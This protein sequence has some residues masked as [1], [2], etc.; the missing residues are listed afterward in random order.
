VPSAISWQ[1]RHLDQDQWFL[2][3]FG[4][5]EFVVLNRLD[6]W[7]VA[8]WTSGSG[9]DLGD[10]GRYEDLPPDLA[11]Q[12]WS[13][14]KDDHRVQLR[15][16]FPD[17]P[18]IARPRHPFTIGPKSN[19]F[20][21][22]GVPASVEVLGA[23]DG[24]M[25][26]L[27]TL[28]SQPLSKTWHGNRSKGSPCYSLRTRARRSVELDDWTGHDIACAVDVKNERA[29]PFPFETLF[30]DTGHLA[31]FEEGGYLWSNALRVRVDED[32][33]SGFNDVTYAP[34]PLDQASNAEEIT[35]PRD[36]RARRSK[37][38]SAFSSFI[39]VIH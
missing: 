10:S 36:G 6:E 8:S 24:S 33:K 2:S 39:D 28:P 38:R 22:I 9:P 25:T 26:S 21:Y 3:T 31:I 19:V 15:P 27:L 20:F 12:R 7:R 35:A 4:P 37:L 29:E 32:R 34:R 23:C 1:E 16:A 30:L 13:C 11:W 18:V 5:L 17:L 14:S